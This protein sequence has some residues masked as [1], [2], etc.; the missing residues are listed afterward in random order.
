[1]RSHRQRHEYA[2]GH[3]RG[4]RD[5]DQQSLS[6]LGSRKPSEA[7]RGLHPQTSLTITAA[8][9]PPAQAADQLRRRGNYGAH[10]RQL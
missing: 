1:M 7:F 10:E 8:E 2:D 6:A 4:E 5:D 3:A 9:T